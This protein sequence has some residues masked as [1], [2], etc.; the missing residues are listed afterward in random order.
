MS[1]SLWP[2]GL[3]H[4]RPPC[5][6][7]SPG[8]CPN[9]SPLSRWC[10]STI[11]SSVIPFSTRLQSFSASGSFQMSQFFISGGQNIGVSASASVLPINTQGWFPLGW[12]IWSPC[13][14]RDSQEFSPTPQFRS[15]NS[16]VLSLLYGLPL[17]SIYDCWKNHG[18]DYTDLC[19]QSNASAFLHTVQVCHSFPP[20]EQVS[21]IFMTEVTIHSDFGA[22]LKKSV[23]V[24]PSIC[25]EVIC[26]DVMILVFWILS[27]RP[28]FS[29][30]SFTHIKRLFCSSSLSTIRV[31]SLHIWDC[32]YFLQ[33]SDSSLCFIQPGISRDVLC[34]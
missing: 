29:L 27:F 1:G 24:S 3:Q 22:P 25:H 20:K 32:W 26:L 23:T 5:P 30:F 17:T 12:L 34:M 28:A 21:F 13:S 6:S 8:V 2:R 11:S 4:A 31:V 10:H 16:L 15:I 33:Q 9:S 19:Q 14:S 7:L 18:F